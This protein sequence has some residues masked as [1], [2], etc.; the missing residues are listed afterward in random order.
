MENSKS[1]DLIIPRGS[2]ELVK[3]IK[4]KSK[5]IPVLGHADGV[6][7]VYIDQYADPE[8]SVEI[9]KE[10]MKNELDPALCTDAVSAF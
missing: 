4:Q 6:C 5:M 2:G 10:N 3:S 1:I 7:H 8:K 9:M